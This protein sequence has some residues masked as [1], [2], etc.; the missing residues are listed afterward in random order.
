MRWALQPLPLPPSEGRLTGREWMAL[1]LGALAMTVLVVVAEPG[2][3]GSLDW[4]RMHGPYKAYAQSA[5]AEGRLPLWNPHAWLGRPFLADIE[6]AFFYPPEALYLF[7]DPHVACALTCALHFL[8]LLYGT[9]KLARALGTDPL[10]SFL[11]AFVFA[12]SAPMVGCFGSGLIHYGQALCFAPL[13][14]YL[15]VRVQAGPRRRDVALFALL[16]GLQVLCGHPQAAWLTEVGL[17]VFLVGRRV[18]R[19]WLPSLARLGIELGIAGAALVLGLALAA[20]ALLPLAELVGQSNRPESSVVFAALFSEPLAGWATLLVPTGLPYFGLQANAQLYAGLVPLLAG[21]CGLAMVSDRNIRGLL[22]LALFA[23]LLAAGEVTPFFRL[24]Y[25]TVPGVGWL[26][27][28]SRATVLVTLALVVAAGLFFSRSQPRRTMVFV[29][30]AAIVLALASV[31]FCLAWPGYG[32]LA[33]TMAVGRGLAALV[34]GMLLALFLWARIGTARRRVLGGLLVALTVVDLSLATHALKQDNRFVAPIEVERQLRG[35]L[36][37]EGLLRPGSP[38]PRLF[39]PMLRE[40]A[41]MVRGFSTPH[42]YSALALGRV[43][44]HLH[45][46]LGV[47]TSSRVTTFPSSRLAAHGSFPY[48]SMALVMGEAPETGLIVRADNPDPRVYVATSMGQVRDDREATALMRAGHD[49]HQTAL[50]EA[51]LPL[52]SQPLEAQAKAIIT[53]YAPEH[54]VVSVESAAPGLLVLAEPWYPGWSAAVNGS[55]APCVPANAW[56]RAVPVPAGSSE[57]ALTFRSTHLAT[58]AAISLGALL[59]IGLLLS[60]GRRAPAGR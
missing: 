13:V 35:T 42:G 31:V 24:L 6:S 11:V 58:G 43:W 45:E 29:V 5:V 3:F 26:R 50:V 14:F 1:L 51:S 55:P 8:L 19:P 21:L 57:V 17:A 44:R 2:S 22:L 28:H 52:P 39:V 10:V 25:Y 48:D 37:A 18:E 56:M 4:V 33:A 59:L 47:E 46:R 12:A 27:I 23:V 53:S 16:L 9:V 7:L 40:N 41:G 60:I 36:V 34:A 32:R 49:F 30:V 38:P 15:G 20:V 54:I